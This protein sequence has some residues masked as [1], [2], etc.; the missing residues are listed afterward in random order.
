MAEFDDSAEWSVG[1]TGTSLN[2]NNGI[3]RRWSEQTVAALRASGLLD[4]MIDGTVAPVDQTALWLDKSTDPAVLKAYNV[5]SGVWEQV[6]QEWLRSGDGGSLPFQFFGNSTILLADTTM[7]YSAGPGISTIVTAGD[8]IDAG[9]IQYEVAAA[10]A[11]DHHETTAGGVKLYES[12]YFFTV[13]A[14]LTDAITRNGSNYRDGSILSAPQ[15]LWQKS[16]LVW[17]ERNTAD[18]AVVIAGTKIDDA[19]NAVAVNRIQQMGARTFIGNPTGSSAT[20]VIMGLTLGLD[21]L[22]FTGVNNGAERSLGLPDDYTGA[23]VTE[24]RFGSLSTN[25]SGTTTYTYDDPFPTQCRGVFCQSQGPIDTSVYE[26][27]VANFTNAT[28]F[29]V[30]VT[31]GGKKTPEIDEEQVKELHAKIGD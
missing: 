26:I 1:T 23:A 8:Y 12:G 6:T 10:A 17:V 14:R 9:G 18:D 5:G 13:E 31:R 30:V 22:G 21:M 11:V 29:E 4:N 15:A 7:G 27:Q 24:F 2:A 16:G 20:P 28:D 3:R 25:A 19:V